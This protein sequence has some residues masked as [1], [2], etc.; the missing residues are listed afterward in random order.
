MCEQILNAP[1]AHLGPRE[2]CPTL[3][4]LIKERRPLKQNN[5]PIAQPVE[6]LPFKEKVVG[7]IPTGRTN[8]KDPKLWVFYIC[9]PKQHIS[10][11]CG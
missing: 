3:F 10:M 1:I 8:I 11:C 4:T 7:S 9:A 6:Q 2:Q 5:A